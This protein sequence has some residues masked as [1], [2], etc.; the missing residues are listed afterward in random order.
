LTG[1]LFTN[2]RGRCILENPKPRYYQT[3][4]VLSDSE[5]RTQLFVPYRDAS[6]SSFVEFDPEVAVGENFGSHFEVG[7]AVLSG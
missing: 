7:G 1:G 4:K 2:R 5:I 6:Y 3:L